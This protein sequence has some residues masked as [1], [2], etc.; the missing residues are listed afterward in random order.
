[1]VLF[2]GGLQEIPHSVNPFYILPHHGWHFKN[3]VT[4]WKSYN[5]LMLYKT[6]LHF[7]DEYDKYVV[8]KGL[9][10]DSFYRRST[11]GK[12][13]PSNAIMDAGIPLPKEK[14]EYRAY[15][16]YLEKV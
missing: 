8:L 7:A 4:V 13:F 1:M 5:Y 2:I 15:R 14:G 11:D 16:W 12:I 9:L 10:P 6:T 3:F